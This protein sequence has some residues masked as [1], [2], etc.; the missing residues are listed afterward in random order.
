[1]S[2]NKTLANLV[3]EVRAEPSY[4][5]TF[6]VA[7]FLSEVNR[8]MEEQNITRSELAAR[9][10][11]SPAFITKLLSANT[12]VTLRT[13]ARVFHALGTRPQI[14]AVKS[15][16]AIESARDAGR[17]TWTMRADIIPFPSCNKKKN[18]MVTA[19]ILESIS[20]SARDFVAFTAHDDKAPFSDVA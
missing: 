18:P 17:S 3:A 2:G 19:S 16:S 20:P 9:L 14:A 1:M 6:A 4:G 5:E 10:D 11:S 12:N 7:H 15:F 8:L 13:M